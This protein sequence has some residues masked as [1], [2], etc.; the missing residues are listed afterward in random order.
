MTALEIPEKGHL[1]PE[2]ATN[3]DSKE[4]TVKVLD[5]I[6]RSC[7]LHVVVLLLLALGFLGV[8]VK[9]RR[10]TTAHLS[11]ANAARPLVT[12]MTS[13]FLKDLRLLIL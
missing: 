11:H 4:V 10:T 6:R 9:T 2:E 5:G 1:V 3:R 8:A 12:R 13:T 7:D